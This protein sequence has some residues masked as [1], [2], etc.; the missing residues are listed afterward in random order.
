MQFS[1]SDISAG[2][3]RDL[4]EM[5]KKVDQLEAEILSLRR[6][7]QVMIFKEKGSLSIIAFKFVL[8][9]MILIPYK[10]NSCSLV[11]EFSP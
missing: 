6:S 2:H 9:R 5:D 8:Y 11:E 3:S 1:N 7:K 10:E 4:M